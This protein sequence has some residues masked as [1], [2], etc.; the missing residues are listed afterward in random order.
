M[1]KW[2]IMA[3][4]MSVSQVTAARVFMCVDPNT[5]EAYFTDAGCAAQEGREE[6]RIEAANLESG[7]RYKKSGKRKTWTSE[8]EEL[9]SG[10]DYNAERRAVTNSGIAGTP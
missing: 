7:K 10:L 4:L 1:Q 9:K 5:G 6:V 3:L 2:I 8:R